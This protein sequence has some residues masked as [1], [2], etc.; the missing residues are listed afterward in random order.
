MIWC[1]HASYGTR[2]IGN[3]VSCDRPAP[4]ACQHQWLQSG[5]ALAK[6][7]RVVAR[8]RGDPDPRRTTHL[9]HTTTSVP[10]SAAPPRF[11]V[12]DIETR[13]DRGTSAVVGGRRTASPAN[14]SLPKQFRLLG[15][16]SP[17]KPIPNFLAEILVLGFRKQFFCRFWGLGFSDK[18]FE[19]PFSIFDKGFQSPISI[20]KK[21]F[22]TP[23][24]FFQR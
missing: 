8:R 13:R 24:S 23:I 2:W 3:L 12:F 6:Q 17:R 4:A 14:S 22:Q 11:F 16:D 15:R 1:V 9:S 21:G 19:S 18:G 10:V 5:D 20:F 7:H